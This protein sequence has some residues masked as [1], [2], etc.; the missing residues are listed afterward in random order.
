MKALSNEPSFV[1]SYRD[2]NTEGVEGMKNADEIKE[3][4]EN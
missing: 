3:K 1:R 2:A 4:R